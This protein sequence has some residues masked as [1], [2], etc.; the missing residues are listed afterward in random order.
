MKHHQTFSIL[1]LAAS[2]RSHM[3]MDKPRPYGYATLTNSPLALADY[4]CKQRQ[5]VYDIVEMNYFSAGEAELVNFNG[6][7]VHGGGSCQ[8]SITT[9]LEPSLSSRWAVIH[10]VEGNCPA[11]NQAG[12]LEGEDPN[13]QGPDRYPLTIPKE[14]PNGQYSLAWSWIN[15]VGGQGEF[16]MDCSPIVVSGGA[17]A[18]DASLD[19][20][21]KLPTMFVANLEAT[22]RTSTIGNKD[23]VYPD[24]GDSLDKKAGLVQQDFAISAGCSSITALGAG[25]GSMTAPQQAKATGGVAKAPVNA[26]NQA[27]IN[28]YAPDGGNTPAQ[29]T[30]GE[31]APSSAA[32][33]PSAATSAA[34][35]NPGGVFA[36]GASSAAATPPPAQTSL[37]TVITQPAAPAPSSV[38]AAPSQS[39]GNGTPSTPSGQYVDCPTNGEVFCISETTFGQCDWGKALV[40]DVAPGT[41]CSYSTLGKLRRSVRHPHHRRHGSQLI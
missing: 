31:E 17:E 8:F 16:Y 6:T 35:S 21:N 18:N 9:D 40:Q 15:N 36:P 5:G 25:S 13:K 12:N 29:P 27:N 10:S 14:V 28:I 33:T 7:A 24:P 11:V 32:A 30:G 34:A 1:A 19:Y 20:L 4:P 39:A 2:V 41:T 26:A 3:I 23:W 37:A 22:C 38:A